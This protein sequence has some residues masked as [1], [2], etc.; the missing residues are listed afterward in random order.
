MST[1][2]DFQTI[3]IGG[4]PMADQKH[5]KKGRAH[6]RIKTTKYS[7]ITFL[8]KNLLEQF[9]RIANFY[10]LVMTTIAIIIGESHACT[11][12]SITKIYEMKN[13]LQ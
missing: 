4:E 7:L 12:H 2:D 1:A 9:R 6:N 11:P 8:P 3:Q 10:F 13:I 5:V